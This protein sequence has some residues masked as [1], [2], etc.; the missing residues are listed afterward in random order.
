MKANARDLRAKALAGCTGIMLAVALV[1]TTG[2]TS[3]AQ[4][5]AAAEQSDGSTDVQQSIQEAAD[6]MDL[7]YSDRDTDA[8]YDEA[9]RRTPPCR[10]QARASRATTPPHRAPR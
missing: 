10:R 4:T 6:K 5:S 1:A 8:S 7:E 3:N 2:C 9:R